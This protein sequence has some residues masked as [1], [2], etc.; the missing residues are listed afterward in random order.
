M[1]RRLFL[2]PGNLVRFIRT[3]RADR[4]LLAEAV[5]YLLYARLALLVIPF[6]R[7][8]QRFG[9]FTA[10]SLAVARDAATPAMAAVARTVGR[11]IRRSA[12]RVPF[13]A[14]CLPQAIA[15]QAMLRRRGVPSVMH[16]GVNANP[17]QAFEAHAWLDAAGV[18][19]SGYPLG[20]HTEIACFV[21]DTAPDRDAAAQ[22]ERP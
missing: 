21:Q 11:A 13:E 5:A 19:V 14:V 17:G 12:R 8:A 18:E 7:L 20:Q 15:A 6:P 4:A 9:R 3:D 22:P 10:P 2:L 1:N 16:F